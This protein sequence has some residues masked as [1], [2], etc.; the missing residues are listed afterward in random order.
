MLRNPGGCDRVLRESQVLVSLSWPLGLAL[1]PLSSAKAQ[2]FVRGDL[3]AVESNLLPDW[4]VFQV[5][6]KWGACDEGV[7]GVE[8][9]Y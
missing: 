3:L 5:P 7:G 9:F 1:S 8:V 4:E 6:E 2:D